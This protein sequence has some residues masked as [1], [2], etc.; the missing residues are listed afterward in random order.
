MIIEPIDPN[1]ML[2][3]A[4]IVIVSIVIAALM[5]ICSDWRDEK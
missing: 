4:G 2:I 3:G 1:S 5:V